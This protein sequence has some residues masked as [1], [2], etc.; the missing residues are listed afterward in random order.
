MNDRPRFSWTICQLK[1]QYNAVASLLQK[2]FISLKLPIWNWM[3]IDLQSR[4]LLTPDSNSLGKKPLLSSKM[5][6]WANTNR[7]KWRGRWTN[8]CNFSFQISRRAIVDSSGVRTV[9]VF[10]LG[11]AVTDT[12][13]LWIINII[14]KL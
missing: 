12:R 14:R 10:P 11:G 1:F 13:W 5:L 6:H 8:G 4:T 2:C 7:L 9:C 3:A